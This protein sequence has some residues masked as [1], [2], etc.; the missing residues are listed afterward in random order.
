V[1]FL[2]IDDNVPGPGF[3]CPP[4]S[5]VGTKLF[6]DPSPPA[7]ILALGPLGPACTPLALPVP[8]GVPP[9]VRIFAQFVFIGTGGP[10]A[11]DASHAVS[12]TIGLPWPAPTAVVLESRVLLSRLA[13]RVPPPRAP[14]LTCHGVLVP[15]D[16]T[17]E[18][19]SASRAERTGR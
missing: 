7:I 3:L 4:A 15:A 18:S 13:T 8:A 2:V 5:A 10:P 14:Q 12:A 11:L 16:G 9:G 19:G 1:A 6:V 17:R